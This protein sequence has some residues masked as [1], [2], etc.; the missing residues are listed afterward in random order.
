MPNTIQTQLDTARN[1]MS[2]CK[3]EFERLLERNQ[4]KALQTVVDSRSTLIKVQVLTS[5][6]VMD[7]ERQIVKAYKPR[8]WWSKKSTSGEQNLVSNKEL[9]YMHRVHKLISDKRF[10]KLKMKSWEDQIPL[11]RESLQRLVQAEQ[12]AVAAASGAVVAGS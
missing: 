1:A 5:H 9:K 10:D 6:V 4:H 11:T 2:D 3:I 8:R 7:A 12:A